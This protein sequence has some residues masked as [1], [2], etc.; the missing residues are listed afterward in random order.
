MTDSN[1][2]FAELWQAMTPNQQKYAI[3]R[4]SGYSTDASAAKSIGISPST[5][6]NWANRKEIDRV[7]YLMISDRKDSAMALL[8]SALPKAIDVLI[9]GLANPKTPRIQQLAAI[10]L[11]D[12]V[13]GRS[14]QRIAPVQVDGVTPYSQDSPEATDRILARIAELAR[15]A[16]ARKQAAE[17][18]ITDVSA[19]Y[20][21]SP[22]EDNEAL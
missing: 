16:E 8:E 13:M 5:A 21:P 14:I 6:R 20:L 17:A 18:L 4:S 3:A 22:D 10:D 12:R 15:L 19:E 9:D 1:D 2:E 11:L 7:I